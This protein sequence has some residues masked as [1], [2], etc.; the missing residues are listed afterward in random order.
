MS[1]LNEKL[2]LDTF[3]AGDWT[4]YCPNCFWTPGKNIAC[5]NECPE[6]KHEGIAVKLNIVEVKEK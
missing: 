4:L 2:K 5:K 1:K 3:S 6:C